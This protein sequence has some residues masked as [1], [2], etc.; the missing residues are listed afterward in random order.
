M[1]LELANGKKEKSVKRTQY[2]VS[3]ELEICIWKS[4]MVWL[5]DYNF[6]MT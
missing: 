1:A 2:G 6:T 5:K 4:E 3:L